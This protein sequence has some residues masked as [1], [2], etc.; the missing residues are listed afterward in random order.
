MAITILQENEDQF[1]AVLDAFANAT[2]N[3]VIPISKFEQQDGDSTKRIKISCKVHVES[4]KRLRV[5]DQVAD[6]L[7]EQADKGQLDIVDVTLGTKSKPDKET[8]DVIVRE[9]PT[10]VIR[11]A[12]KPINSGG[13]GGGSAA[14][15]V[16]ETALATFLAM[17]YD[18][19]TALECHP[20][21]S[22]GCI[23]EDDYIKGLKQVDC[24]GK[25]TVEEIMGG[26]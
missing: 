6:Y 16:Q 22:D 17:R 8:L 12:I 5:R 24:A 11:I 23:D 3:D 25:V 26:Y 4:G 10:E 9:N 7:G 2:D 19:G 21:R 20:S 18:K 13:S 15:T 1:R 14:T